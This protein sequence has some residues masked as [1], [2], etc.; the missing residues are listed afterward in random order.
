MFRE[1]E[2]ERGGRWGGGGGE[3]EEPETETEKIMMRV[4]DR[5]KRA[6]RAARGVSWREEKSGGMGWVGEREIERGA[7]GG[8]EGG[9]VEAD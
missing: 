7:R 3:G 1:R 2:R 9:G 5:T 8:V 4:K 6:F